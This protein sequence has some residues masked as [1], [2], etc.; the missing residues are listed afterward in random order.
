MIKV[1]ILA[2]GQGT[3]LRP[4]TDD[5]PK[6]LVEIFGKTILEHQID[7][8]KKCGIIDIN[9]V[10]GFKSKQIKDLG[11]KTSSN[12]NYK[13][14]NM[15]SSLFSAKEFISSCK[16]EDLIISYG[17]I[18]FQKENLEKLIDSHS[19]LSIMNDKSWEQLWKLRMSDPLEDAETFILD[20]SNYV[21]ELGKK[22]KNY[23]SIQGQFTG[24]I[25]VD[26]SKIDDIIE[27]YYS[28]DKTN[29]Y[30]GKDYDNMF[31]TSFIQL[32]IDLG[33]KVKAVDV[34]NGWLEVDTAEDLLLYEKLKR[35]KRLSR[36]YK[37]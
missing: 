25:K 2:A 26:K 35:N 11:Y 1:V 9:I 37:F 23:E 14:T 33:W 7:T 12:N 19:E 20:N 34:N 17:D 4:Y 13:R 31:M 16:N 6:C 28:L 22:P 3:R 8:F 27:T 18:I 21:I 32:L 29:M 15:V 30:D 10:T 36:F 5:K 24:L